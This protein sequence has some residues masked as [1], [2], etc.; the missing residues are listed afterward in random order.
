MAP[1][2][3]CPKAVAWGAARMTQDPDIAR[4][5]LD[6]VSVCHTGHPEGKGKSCSIPSQKHD[7]GCCC[8]SPE[9][10]RCSLSP[11]DTAVPCPCS[12]CSPRVRDL[13]LG[14]HSGTQMFTEEEATD[15]DWTH[16]LVAE[17]N[18]ALSKA[19][20]HNLS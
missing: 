4:A 6:V 10:G 15:S 3:L 17:V 20:N 9:E 18:N 5:K 8:Q 14:C 13:T 12:A 19:I 2:E 1:Q 16:C 11:C 7:P